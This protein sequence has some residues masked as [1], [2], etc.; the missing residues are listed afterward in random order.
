MED[1]KKRTPLFNQLILKNLDET[2]RLNFRQASKSIDQVL[3]KERVYWILKMNKYQENFKEF[4]ESWKAVISKTPVADLKHLAVAAQKFFNGKATRI[5]E[6]WHPL[7][8]AA[9]QD[10]LDLCKLIIT[11][12]PS[13]NDVAPILGA[14]TFYVDRILRIFDP[15][16]PVASFK[17]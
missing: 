5:D 1:L 12:G 13:I 16:P 10:S 14:F 8:I 11:K 2:S 3:E 17:P 9:D 7:F 15:L 4:K 6:Q